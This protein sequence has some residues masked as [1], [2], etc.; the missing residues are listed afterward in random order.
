MTAIDPLFFMD[1]WPLTGVSFGETFQSYP[2]RRVVRLHAKE[3]EFVA[4]MDSEPSAPETALRS[5]AVYGF[6][7]S[8]GFAHIPRLLDATNGRPVVY[9]EHM[10]V[11]VLEFIEGGRPAPVP[12]TW[13]VLGQI[14]AKLNSIVD[15]PGSYA[16]PTEGVIL[17]LAEEAKDHPARRRFL[18]YVD[19]LGPLVLYPRQGLIHGEINLG[20]AM[21]RR[22]GELVLIDWDEAGSGATVLEAGYPL[23]TV[24]LTEDLCFQ[25][26]LAVAFYGAYYGP[27][28]PDD[29][30]K[31]L[32]FRS[33]L[34]HALRY[35]R[36]GNRQKRWDRIC[37][38]VAH[39]ESLLANIF[40]G[41]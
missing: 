40:G 8:R 3:G 31:D 30:E 28:Q 21:Q 34:L 37:H 18:E 39:R 22:N 14:A 29:A 5:L 15:F 13:K 19:R 24:F 2:S 38:A 12:A 11:T 26:E 41:G 35:A 27:N 1:H 25:R 6:L 16:V 20:N 10:S 36:Y 23:L 32:V 17:E 33:A 4:K 9:S 7:T